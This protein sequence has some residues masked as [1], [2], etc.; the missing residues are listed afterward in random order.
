[1]ESS[2]R[3]GT[4]Y[5]N[6]SLFIFTLANKQSMVP[7]T[8]AIK[9]TAILLQNPYQLPWLERRN[10]FRHALLSIHIL[11]KQVQYFQHSKTHAIL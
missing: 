3:S 9:R 2:F 6:D 11:W 8:F 4:I 10:I 5:G 1:M 7:F